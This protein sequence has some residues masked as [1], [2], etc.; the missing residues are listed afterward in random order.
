MITLSTFGWIILSVLNPSQCQV[1]QPKTLDSLLV[2]LK[3]ATTDTAKID[4]QLALGGVMIFS[5]SLQSFEYLSG[6]VA[7][8][9]RVDDKARLVASLTKLA[10][11]HLVR[12]NYPLALNALSEAE[13]QIKY[14][15]NP[16][17]KA[18][19]FKYRG[20]ANNFIGRYDKAI[21]DL[22]TA[23]NLYE[24]KKDSNGVAHC[25]L[26]IGIT[27]MNM[28]N[29]DKSLENY[30]DAL[31]IYRSLGDETRMAKALGNIGIVYKRKGEF[32]KA[33]DHYKQSLLINEK[34]KL[35]FD[36]RM[37][38]NNLGV[39]Y[40]ET[41]NYKKA[42]EY[43]T[44]S[45]KIARELALPQYIL[46]ADFNLALIDYELNNPHKAIRELTKTI[47]TAK[48]LGYKEILMS[49]YDVLANAYEKTG[50]YGLALENRKAFEVY[51]DSLINESNMEKVAEL[52]MQ[53][54]TEKKDQ[55]IALLAKEKSL[56]QKEAQRQGTIKKAMI[57][58][59]VLLVLLAASL[60]YNSRQKLKNQ[61]TLAEKD[62]KIN[63]AHFK[64]ELSRL[65]MKALH[66]Q[67]N[68]HFLFNCMTSINL[69][70][71]ENE[72][73]KASIYLAKFSKLIRSILENCEKPTVSLKKEIE[74]LEAYIQLEKLRFKSKLDYQI[75]IDNEIDADDTYLPAMIL[76]P[77]VEN[78]ILHGIVPKNN[79]ES[80]MVK[81]GVKNGNEES[82][83]CC[84]EDNGIGRENAA[85]LNKK[86][87]LKSKSMGI[88][89]NRER[90]NL[91]SKNGQNNAIQ[92]IDLKDAENEAIGTR[93]EINIPIFN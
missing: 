93:V 55:Q 21:N 67:I 73:E 5:D 23:I 75:N 36:T 26:N 85:R 76:Q 86:S 80:G 18:E 65:E 89:I 33:I 32:A 71:L 6:A 30:N 42:L 91:I 66:A 27:N 9:E 20:I 63:E 29:Y 78:A 2:A 52:Q 35:R 87:S 40:A 38:L 64:E 10:N 34:Y 15:G 25:Y 16:V 77:F 56:Q 57:F 88:K 45:K 17:V 46:T 51:K 58:G 50:R 53:Y 13:G 47:K 19:F 14:A 41:G 79:G 39:L 44:R 49:S 8:A 82:L 60:I 11:Y 7:L 83:L 22:F 37:D 69:M 3:S 59:S 1:T 4:L 31:A 90:L 84:I 54:E 92:I 48:K 81:I 62:R 28:K 12:G 74:L 72:N 61:K 43:H 70:I 68:P 24:A